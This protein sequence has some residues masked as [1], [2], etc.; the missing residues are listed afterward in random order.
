M[1]GW[2]V[3]VCPCVLEVGGFVCVGVGRS[4]RRGD[5]FDTYFV[6]KKRT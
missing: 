5:H 2:C 3:G 4:S 1:D 6:P